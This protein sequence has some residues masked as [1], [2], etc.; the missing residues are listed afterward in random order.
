MNSTDLINL[1][2]K[3]RGMTAPEYAKHIRADRMTVYRWT[4][5]NPMSRSW[6]RLVELDVET[7]QKSQKRNRRR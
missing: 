1:A 7:A 4:W 6:R 5:G 2:L 3:V